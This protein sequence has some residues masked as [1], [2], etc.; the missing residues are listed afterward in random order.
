MTAP[1]V[2]IL[3][4]ADFDSAVWT[5]KQHLA[6]GLVE[7]GIDVHYVESFGLREPR[8]SRA[9]LARAIRR[10][11][12]AI[13]GRRRPSGPA[14]STTSSTARPR[15]TVISPFVIPFHRSS[16]VRALNAFLVRT[17]LLPRLPSGPD[18]I[19]WTFS[20]LTYGLERIAGST[21][22]HSVDL[23]HHQDRAPAKV[24]IENE[25]RLVLHADR[26]IAS[27]AGVRQHIE[28]LGREDVLLWENVADVETYARVR[29]ERADTAIFAGNLTPSKI[30]VDL[31]LALAEYEIDVVLAGPLAVDG[32]SAQT[33]REVLDHP[34][35]R[36]LGNLQPERLAEAMASAR[37]GLIPYADNPYTRGVF[38]MKVY[39][40]MAAGLNVVA[41]PLPS[42]MASNTPVTFAN[43]S[44]YPM[45]V[46]IAIAAWTEDGADARREIA[47]A[48]SWT[49]RTAEAAGLVRMLAGIGTNDASL[50]SAR[51]E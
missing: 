32:T 1:R 13:L 17:L 3:A 49:G 12:D 45:A 35:I 24:L 29:V 18:V 41:T 5:N 9:D 46:A 23:L 14:D 30:D 39:E 36:Y 47:A 48:H 51:H 8:M 20:P 2:V 6:V 16:F 43:V 31:L 28:Q 19:L 44:S 40:Y 38:P 15:P 10:L 25:Q 27:S 37:V 26:V 33:M 11:R 50:G 42:M 34:R 21:I 22:Y 4:T 7:R